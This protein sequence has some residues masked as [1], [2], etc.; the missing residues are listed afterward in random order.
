MTMDARSEGN[1][2]H[3]FHEVSTLT[4]ITRLGFGDEGSLDYQYRN[5]SDDGHYGRDYQGHYRCAGSARGLAID[6]DR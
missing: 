6:D 4:F 2:V 3:L 1:T 5:R